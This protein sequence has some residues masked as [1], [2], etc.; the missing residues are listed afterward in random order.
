VH[1]AHIGHPLVG[2]PVYWRR[3]PVRTTR[4]ELVRLLGAFPRQALHAGLLGF[5]H[6]ITGARLRFTAPPPADLSALRESL[7]KFKKMP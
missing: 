1:L 4:P 7:E 2:D 6:P 5:D 3:T